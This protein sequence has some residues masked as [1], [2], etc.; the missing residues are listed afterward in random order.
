MKNALWKD[1]FRDIKKTKGRFISIVSIIALGVMLFTGV[2]MAPEDMKGSA[3]KYYDDYNLMDLRVISTLGLTD[4]D[5]KDIKAID[6]VLGAYPE[7]TVDA[8]TKVGNDE[9][10][11]RVQSVPNS[12]LTDSN[13]DYINRLNVVEGRLPE[14][15]G[16]CVVAK[17]KFEGT[18]VNIGDTITLRSGKDE[19]ITNSLK[20]KEFKVVGL[21]ETPYYLSDQIGSTTIGSGTVSTF[22]YIPESD[23]TMDA[24]TDIYVTVKDAKNLNSYKDEYFDVVDKVKEAIEDDSQVIIDR[25]YNEIKDIAIEELNKGKKEYEEKKAEVEKQLSDA[26]AQIEDTKVQLENAEA[27]IVN[28]EAELNTM[29]ANGEAQLASGEAE[30]ANRTAEYEAGVKAFNDAK[31]AA[32]EGFKQAEA[33]LVEAE[34]K[35]APLVQRKVEIEGK[36]SDTNITE[37]EK[38]VLQAELATIE[39]IITSSLEQ[40]NA[41]KSELES[42]KTEFYNQEKALTDAKAQLDGARATIESTRATLQAAKSEGATQLANAKAKVESGKVQLAE[43]EAEY[44]K[45]KTLADEELLKAGE[46]IKDAENQVNKIG[47]PSFYVLDRNSHYSYVDYENSASSIDKLSNVFPVFFFVV[48]ALVCLTTMT[49]MVDEQ[50]INIGTMKALG[51]SNGNIAKKFIV[52][53]LLASLIGSVIGMAIGFT[54]FP[55]VIYD[56]YN[57]MYIMPPIT[58]FINIPLAIVT[59]IASIGL[60]TLATY[61]ACRIELI[62]TPSVLMRPK[63]PKEGKRI[64]L[65]RIPFIWNRFNFTG[66]VTIR[67]I[68]RYK[69]RFLMTVIGIAGSTALLLAGFGIKDSI[70]TVVSKQFGTINKYDISVNLEKDIS[71]VQKADLET[72]MKD[73]SDIKDFLF[74]KGEM[75]KVEANDES[76][77]LDIIVPSD[78]DRFDEFTHLQ[79][80]ISKETVSLNDDGIAITEKVAKVLGV[81]VG[82]EVTITNSNDVTG[83]AKVSAIVENYIQHYIYM[84][85][86]YY[87]KVFDRKATPDE[88]YIILNNADNTVADSVSNGLVNREGVSGV[89]SNT[90]IRDNFNNTIESLDFVVLVMILAAGALSFIVLYNLTNVNISERIR[91]I[92]TIKVLGFY[93]KEV[94]AYIFRENVLLTVIGMFAGLLLGVVFHQFIMITVEMDYVMFGRSINT[95][96]YVYAGLLTVG[97]S[98][99][100][101]WAMYFKL[102]KVQMVESLK[103]VD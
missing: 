39:P 48:A 53:A 65:E 46:K 9:F 20:N 71:S 38:V 98:L 1:I 68:F 78:V 87:E 75:S 81:K 70:K 54:F 4:E 57:I 32:E 95:M 84:T 7:Y 64:L 93:D 33:A 41:G 76:K 63:A 89:V 22:M 27:E 34:N 8:L 31:P 90:G 21:I 47:K 59:A 2:K 96:S 102:K 51:Y 35:I 80:R 86:N 69:K 15:S 45:N 92:A 52:Y 18:Q 79:N 94:A 36:L 85:P 42:K 6:G 26:K 29:I 103:S 72:Y 12:N 17:G 101:N 10:V 99:L 83:T 24:Y 5:V 3:D 66:K 62:E 50:R 40:I 23:F 28:K 13:E 44:E 77:D 19:D 43:G 37:E 55:K 97:F 11:I 91:E 25:R 100:V 67:N 30:L 61:S 49:R 82:D 74:V 88:A 60:T 14:N 16:D 58:L 73:Q 56:A